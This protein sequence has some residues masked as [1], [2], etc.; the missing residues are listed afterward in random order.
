MVI[1]LLTK[2]ALRWADV[3]SPQ[4]PL[5]SSIEYSSVLYVWP[6]NNKE[7]HKKKVNFA[8][9]L[10]KK[11]LIFHYNGNQV[12]CVI[13]YYSHVIGEGRRQYLPFLKKLSPNQRL[14]RQNSER[15]R[16]SCKEDPLES[17]SCW[18]GCS[19]DDA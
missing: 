7:Y 18:W 2:P 14:V 6:K 15:T 4:E 3:E 19:T 16:R 5:E 12:E 11:L 13:T 1:F 9:E 17:K 8:A 10:I